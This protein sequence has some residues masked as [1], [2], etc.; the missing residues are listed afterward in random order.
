MKINCWF[1][2]WNTV[3]NVH[4]FQLPVE[5]IYIHRINYNRTRKPVLFPFSMHISN[6]W[7]LLLLHHQILL[8]VQVTECIIGCKEQNKVFQKY[9]NILRII[10]QVFFFLEAKISNK[11]RCENMNLYLLLMNKLLNLG[12]LIC[13]YSSHYSMEFRH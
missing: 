13:T 11:N 1:I 6:H 10:T 7:M 3:I 8:P 4:K 9:R 2:I 12:N 5:K